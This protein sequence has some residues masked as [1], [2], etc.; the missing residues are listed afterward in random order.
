MAKIQLDTPF[1]VGIVQ[2]LLYVQLKELRVGMHKLVNEN[3]PE[4]NKAKGSTQ[5]LENNIGGLPEQESGM[6]K[7]KQ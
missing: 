4:K 1:T 7:L 3:G 5:P 6:V 2:Q